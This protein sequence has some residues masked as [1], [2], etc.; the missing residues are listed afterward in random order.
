M[1]DQQPD[2]ETRLISLTQDLLAS[3]EALVECG[4]DSPVHM[5]AE[6]A[7]EKAKAELAQLGVAAGAVGGGARPETPGTGAT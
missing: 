1:A 5:R 3:L 2:R 7:I 6:R 4:T